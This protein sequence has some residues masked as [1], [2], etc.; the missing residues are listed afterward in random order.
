VERVAVDLDVSA[1]GHVRRG[2]ELLVLVHVLVLASLEEGSRNDSRVLLSGLVNRDTVVG[3]VER[4]DKAAVDVLGH[5][6]V[7]AGSEA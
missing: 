7:E 4:N 3:H 5:A 1:N 2:D 6:R